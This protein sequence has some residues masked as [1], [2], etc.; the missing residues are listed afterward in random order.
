MICPCC[1][2]ELAE[3]LTDAVYSEMFMAFIHR[4]CMSDCGEW[5]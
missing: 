4:D 1:H 5:T 2:E 3:P